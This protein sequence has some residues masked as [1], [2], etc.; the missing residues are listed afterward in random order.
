MG[1]NISKIF[2]RIIFYDFYGQAFD[3]RSSLD[4]NYRIHH[5]TGIIC[6]IEYKVDNAERVEKNLENVKIRPKFLNLI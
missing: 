6:S 3:I 5:V 4:V 1:E 2:F